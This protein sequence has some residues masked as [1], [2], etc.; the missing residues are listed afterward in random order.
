MG[1]LNLEFCDTPMAEAIIKE[2]FKSHRITPPSIRRARGVIS[3]TS[4]DCT[5][6]LGKAMAKK[7]LFALGQ[8]EARVKL[9]SSDLDSVSYVQNLSPWQWKT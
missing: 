7:I 4:R 8:R 1:L 2:T 5:H 3:T 9:I 6:S